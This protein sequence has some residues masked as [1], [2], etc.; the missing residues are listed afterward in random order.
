MLS[1]LSRNTAEVETPST[2]NPKF[3]AGVFNHFTKLLVTS[4]ETNWLEPVTVA[5][6]IWVAEEGAVALVTAASVQAEEASE[7]L[8]V[9]AV[10]SLLTHKTKLTRATEVAVVPDGRV[11]KSNCKKVLL[12]SPLWVWP[13]FN[14]GRLPKLRLGVRELTWV[15]P[16]GDRVWASND[17]VRHASAPTSHG[18]T[19]E[20]FRDNAVVD[21]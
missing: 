7:I 2:T 4:T 15:S 11:D 21:T 20:H 8:I 19:A 6:P 16:D 18:A 1:L 9:P 14:W 10:P 5:V 17:C 12:V 3:D 13:T